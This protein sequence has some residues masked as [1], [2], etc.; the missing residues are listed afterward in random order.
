MAE[1]HDDH[2]Q[3]KLPPEAEFGVEQGEG[4]APGGEE[5]DADCQADQQHHAGLAGAD[6]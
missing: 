2:Q 6:F 4:G 3:G 5:C 1:Q